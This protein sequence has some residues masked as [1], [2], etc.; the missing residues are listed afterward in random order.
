MGLARIRSGLGALRGEGND[1][2]A[3]GPDRARHIVEGLGALQTH[4]RKG[5]GRHFL[6][7]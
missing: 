5:T 7:Q 4:R 2:M 1:V 6:E 3:V